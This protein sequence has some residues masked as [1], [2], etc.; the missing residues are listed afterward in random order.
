MSNSKLAKQRPDFRA[1]LALMVKDVEANHGQR[2]TE[3]NKPGHKHDRPGIWN[4]PDGGTCESCAQWNAAKFALA[5]W[6]PEDEATHAANALTNAEQAGAWL[7][8]SEALA[9]HPWLVHAV[10][11]HGTYQDAAVGM[12]HYL[13][14]TV[15]DLTKPDAEKM[16]VSVTEGQ[17]LINRETRDM[18]RVLAISRDEKY[19][20]R[21]LVTYQLANAPDSPKWTV[22]LDDFTE[23]FEPASV[24]SKDANVHAHYYES[25]LP[26]ISRPVTPPPEPENDPQLRRLADGVARNIGQE[27]LA[28][29]ER[30][31]ALEEA[32][33]VDEA[34]PRN[35]AV[36][37]HFNIDKS[38][39]FDL[40]KIGDMVSARVTPRVA[41][42]ITTE[43]LKAIVNDLWDMAQHIHQVA[44]D[45]MWNN[46]VDISK[47]RLQNWRARLLDI[48]EV[49]RKKL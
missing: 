6:T 41:V 2:V 5:H 29:T 48:R 45:P 49:L 25:G 1:I 24:A 33:K 42:A 7:K 40:T 35:M 37:W 17:H 4:G 32:A 8:V 18:Y 34:R 43:D 46:R 38:M 3:G 11:Y 44:L 39:D 30:V 20:G 28:L 16:V 10:I 21:T 19:V 9:E 47:N 13:A 26:E 23:R 15:K 36:G 27:V 31:K 22:N 14:R 12:I